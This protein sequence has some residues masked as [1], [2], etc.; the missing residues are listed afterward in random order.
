M[1]LC[2]HDRIDYYRDMEFL[3]KPKSIKRL[4]YKELKPIIFKILKKVFPG[5]EV[6]KKRKPIVP[7]LYHHP[8]ILGNHASIL[9]ALQSDL[10]VNYENQI[11]KAVVP[12]V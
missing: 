11:T 10:G 3:R 5:R 1:E 12:K 8:S 6:L 9:G 2:E 4:K 7:N